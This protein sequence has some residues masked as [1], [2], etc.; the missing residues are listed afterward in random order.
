M[1][2]CDVEGR[3]DVYDKAE[4]LPLERETE[5]GET[6]T[7]IYNRVNKCGSST[8]LSKS[9]LLALSQLADVS[10]P[11]SAERRELPDWGPPGSPGGANPQVLPPGPEISLGQAC[12][13]ARQQGHHQSLLLLYQHHGV[14]LQA[15]I[16]LH[17]QSHFLSVDNSIFH[18]M[19][20]NDRLETPWRGSTP[21]TDIIER[22]CPR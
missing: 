14:R 21:G 22:F 20:C 18:I 1:N 15:S 16:L 19:C 7:V 17:G 3:I 9:S 10:S 8:L 2:E 12:L 4:A 11:S 6:D 13:P 5:I